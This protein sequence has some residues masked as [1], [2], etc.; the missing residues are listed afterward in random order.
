L[1]A[2]TAAG[3]AL[4]PGGAGLAVIV[5]E[6]R[7]LC[8][9]ARLAAA[10][11]ARLPAAAL[12]LVTDAQAAWHVRERGAAVVVGA[13]A[14]LTGQHSGGGGGVVVNKVGT[15]A[16]AAAAADAGSPAFA[17]AGGAKLTAVASLPALAAGCPAGGGHGG[18]ALEEPDPAAEVAPCLPPLPPSVA[19]RN[20]YFEAT[21][22]SF[23]T[24]HGGGVVVEGGVLRS[25]A[26]VEGAG[27]GAVARAVDAF[28]LDWLS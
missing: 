14:V 4:G 3:E 10:L 1:D 5:C 12:T 27:A 16:L 9:G 22:L 7:P 25:A 20:V 26:E 8:E 28:G 6:A 18:G 13:D 17:V 19:L 11:A 2:L 21:P 23:F 15:W 24:D